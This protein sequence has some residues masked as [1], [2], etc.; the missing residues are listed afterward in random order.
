ML[1]FLREPLAANLGNFALALRHVA[2]NGDIGRRNAVIDSAREIELAI[3]RER[4]QLR[5]AGGRNVFFAIALLA[6]EFTLP[7]LQTLGD[8]GLEQRRVRLRLRHLLL[9][10]RRFGLHCL[11][12][13][14]PVRRGCL[15]AQRFEVLDQQRQCQDAEVCAARRVIEQLDR[16]QLAVEKHQAR[17]QIDESFLEFE[18]DV[19][20]PRRNAAHARTALPVMAGLDNARAV[21]AGDG[22]HIHYAICIENDNVFF[23]AHGAPVEGER[24]SV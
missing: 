10:F 13:R 23:L 14:L 2:K 15:L 22:I 7:L 11:H 1:D 21:D 20:V 5:A 17:E 24:W 8:D 16:M 18:G 3:G 12:L 4:R 9:H 19:L 6:R